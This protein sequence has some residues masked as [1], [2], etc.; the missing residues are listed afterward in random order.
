MILSSCGQVPPFV[1][2]LHEA[3]IIMYFVLGVWGRY[4]TGEQAG[5]PFEA[6]QKCVKN[7][8]INIRNILEV[9]GL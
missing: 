9:H 1:G 7:V 3:C 4:A 6:L 8:V 5:V 2:V